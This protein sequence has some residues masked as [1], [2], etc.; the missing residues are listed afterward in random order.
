[1][2]IS[3]VYI[4]SNH[5]LCFYLLLCLYDFYSFH[6][7][8]SYVSF[9]MLLFFLFSMKSLFLVAFNL[10][11]LC[12]SVLLFLFLFLVCTATHWLL[13]FCI[14]IYSCNYILVFFFISSCLFCITALSD[15]MISFYFL[16][17]LLFS[18]YYI[19]ILF[20]PMLSF[21]FL[22]ILV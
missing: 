2:Y 6:F 3:I 15:V 12:Y 21:V 16:H 5:Y 22:L 9:C 18:S 19:F 8:T 4:Y 11:L 1:M 20:V 17:T 14:F 10:S 7:S 13:V